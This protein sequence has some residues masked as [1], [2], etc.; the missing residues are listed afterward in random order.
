MLLRF[1]AESGKLSVYERHPDWSSEKEYAIS[2]DAFPFLHQGM[3]LLSGEEIYEQVGP[4]DGRAEVEL[5]VPEGQRPEAVVS[6]SPIVVGLAAKGEFLVDQFVAVDDKGSRRSRIT[7][8]TVAHHDRQEGRQVRRRLPGHGLRAALFPRRL[9]SGRRHGDTLFLPTQNMRP[10]DGDREYNKIAAFGL[11]TGRVTWSADA[12]A[13]RAAFP[14]AADG[15]KVIAYIQATRENGGRLVR[16]GPATGA[17]SVDQQHPDSESEDERDAFGLS[18][19]MPRI[20]T[21]GSCS[22]SP[23]R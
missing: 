10:N 17:T 4:G 16:F 1:D 11:E 20:R 22:S 9:R 19:P 15:G 3:F 23:S 6:T 18:S 13:K 14:Q 8:A 21:A 7:I 12:G 2:Q 5:P